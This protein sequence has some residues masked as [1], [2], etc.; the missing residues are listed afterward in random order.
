ML[1]GIST[2]V[3]LLIALGWKFRRQAGL[4]IVIMSIAFIID[5]ALLL[6]IE[7]NR[8]AIAH[9]SHSIMT[10]QSDSLLYFHVTV[11]ALTLVLYIVQITSGIKLFKGWVPSRK[12]HQRSA[13]LFI[14]CRLLN[15]ATSF[16]IPTT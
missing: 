10:A 2:F 13:M 8:H 12:F 11:S 6:Y 14:A 4:H 9:V 16:F 1:Y 15:Y 5:F 3:L 7:L